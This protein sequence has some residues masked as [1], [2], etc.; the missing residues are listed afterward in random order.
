MPVALFKEYQHHFIRVIWNLVNLGFSRDSFPNS[1]KKAIVTPI[2]KKG[3]RK[4]CENYRP[5][6]VLPFKSKISE[7][8]IH[9]RIYNLVCDFSIII[10]PQNGFMKGRS[11]ENAIIDLTE[12][13]YK[14]LDSKQFGINT[15]IDFRRAFDTTDNHI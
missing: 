10:D 12:I 4:I 14:T 6:S 11:T 15:F 1:L 3:D 5:I 13:I 2:F 8:C 7:R 9:N